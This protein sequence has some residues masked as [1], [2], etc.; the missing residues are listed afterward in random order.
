MIIYQASCFENIWKS[1]LVVNEVK[2]V[3]PKKICSPAILEIYSGAHT[4]I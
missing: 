4:L 3:W 2:K 1:I